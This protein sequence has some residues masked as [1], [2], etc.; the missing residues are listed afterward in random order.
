MP[1]RHNKS[2]IVMII[3]LL[4]IG[5]LYLYGIYQKYRYKETGAW[6]MTYKL[7]TRFRFTYMV[8]VSMGCI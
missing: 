6:S 3:M 2:I 7:S 5:V 4:Y 1:L 8:L